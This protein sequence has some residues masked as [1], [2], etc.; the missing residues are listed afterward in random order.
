MPSANGAVGAGPHVEPRQN[1]WAR[2][3]LGWLWLVGLLKHGASVL[4]VGAGSV[5]GVDAMIALLGAAAIWPVAIAVV[6]G[7]IGLVNLGR[8]QLRK[9]QH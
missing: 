7:A 3:T 2:L 9:L 4:Y 8:D 6:V 5:I 1:L